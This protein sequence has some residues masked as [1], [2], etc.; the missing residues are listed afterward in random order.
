[1]GLS[2]K[3][4]KSLYEDTVMQIT[5]SPEEWAS[6]LNS[7][8]WM[9]EYDF[10]EQLLIYAQRPD[11]KACATIEDWNKKVYRWVKS[12]S[13]G[14]TILKYRDGKMK[15]EN[16]FDMADT[17]QK[18]GKHFNLWKLN[19]D[20]TS[21]L[22]ESLEA[23]YGEL[24]T[25]TDLPFAIIA[26]VENC[27]DDNIQDYYND[28]MFNI[29]G[30]NLER[31]SS[32]EIKNIYTSLIKVSVIYS[33]M[34]RVDEKPEKLFGIEDFKH[35][36]DF[37]TLATITAIGTAT[38]EIKREIIRE[39]RNFVHNKNHTFD[40][41]VIPKY[42]KSEEEIERSELNDNIQQTGRISNTEHS[43]GE[44]IS[45]S[46]REIRQ[47]EREL[48]KR[49]QE[50][51]LSDI[52]DDR[53]ISATF[54]G[55]TANSRESSGGLDRENESTRED[56]RRNETRKSDEMGRI[57]EQLE[58]DS[59]GNSDEGVNIQLD[60]YK[61]DERLSYVVV[62][63]KVNQILCETELINNRAVIDYFMLEKD[64]E[65][66][67]NFLKSAINDEYTG[68]VLY[69]EMY[70]Y[71]AF[72]NGVLF[73]KGNYLTKSAE[74]LISWE[75]L[76][77][78][79]D[80]MILLRQIR[81]KKSPL[82][83]SNG[84]LSLLEENSSSE[85]LEFTQEFLERYLSG[86][87]S[88]IKQ[89]I[90]EQFTSCLSAEENIKYIKDRYGISGA[91]S[92]VKGSGIGYD[93]SAKGLKL[94]RGFFEGRLEKTFSWKHIQETIAKLIREDKYLTSTEKSKYEIKDNTEK[95]VTL[96]IPKPITEVKENKLQSFN[97]QSESNKDIKN[98]FVIK[99]DKL[100]EGTPKER[101]KNNIEAIKVLKQC[102]A[103]NRYATTDEQEKLARYVG[104]GGLSQA[105]DEKNDSWKNEYKELK[106]L[107]TEEE[108]S[109]AR[110]ST[111]TAFYT[112]PIVI[113]SIYQ[114]LSNMGLKNGNILEPS[115]GTGNFI[116][117]I[118]EELS[119]CKMYG[120]ELDSITG[121]IAQQ[122]YQKSTIAIKGY[123]EADIPDTFFDAAVGNI[124]FG[125][126]KVTD[127]RYDKNNFL[128]H[129]YFFA[130]TLDKVR[131]GGIIAFITSKGT[132]DKE[133][134]SIR[135]YIAQR[136]DLLGAVRL[137]DNTFKGSAGT[138]VTTDII[139]LQKREQVLDI[140]PEWVHL[141]KNEDEIKM[142]RY[143]IDNPNMILGQ[144]KMETS[145][146]GMTANCKAFEN[147]DLSEL[148]E[149]A[150]SNIKA[151]I[152]DYGIGE[153]VNEEDTSIPAELNVKNFSYTII[154]D[155]IYYRDGSKMFLQDVPATNKSRIKELIKIRDCVRYLIDLQTEDRE[156]S[157]IIKEQAK[158]NK[159]YD[160]FVK[161]Y[162]RIYDNSNKRA[163]S[164]DS[165]YYLLCSLE[166][167]DDKGKFVRK[168]DMFS[169]RTIKPHRE[170]VAVATS[171]EALIV[172]I[173]EKAKVDL[174]YMS[175]LCSKSKDEI[176]SEL[177]GV[178]FKVPYSEDKYVTADEYL[179][180]NVREKLRTAEVAVKEDKSL[181]INVEML[182]KS[183]PKDLSAS[184]ISVRLGSTWLPEKY[185]E[186]FMYEL[187][188]TSRYN[189]EHIKVHYSDATSSWNISHKSYDN[190]NVK[191]NNTY[192]TDRINAYKIIEETLNL[193]SV[194]VF[195]TVYDEEGNKK[196]VL[197]K[198]DTAIAQAKQEQIKQAFQDWIWKEHDRREELTKLYNERFNSI[199]PR[200]YDGSHI[201]FGGINPEINLRKHQ[202]NAIAHILYGGNTLL[203]HEVGAGKTFEMVAAAM[204]SKRLNLCNKSIIVVP[205]HIVDQ[206]A[207]EFLQLYPSANL[208]V[209]TKKDFSTNYRKRFC[210]KIATGDY[211][212]II[213]GHSQFEK[214]PMSVER[215]KVLLNQQIADIQNGI[216]E[217]KANNGERFSI[218]DLE[219]SKKKLEEKLKKLN[220]QSRKD[221]VITFEQL[222][223]D[224][225]FV[226]EAH[227]YKNLFMYT[228]MRN[229]GGI[230]QTDA[231]KSSDLFMKCRY[232]DE[233]T[234]NK[235]VIFATGTPISNSMVELY[236]MQRYLQYDTLLENKLQHFDAW[237]STFGETVTAIE[238][239]PEGTGYRP[240]TRFAKFH[241]LPELM[242]MFKEIADIQTAD[243]LNLPAPDA[244]FHNVVVKPSE[245]QKSMVEELGKRAEKIRRG[246]ID[247]TVDNM[248]K[249]TND[250]RKLALDQRLLNPLLSDF[251]ESKINICANNIYKIWQE[252]I[253]EK[254]A[255]LAFCDLSTPKDLVTSKE[256]CSNVASDKEYEASFIDAYT[257]LKCKL[258]K[259]GIP[260]EEIAFIHEADDEMKKR[261]LFSKVRSGTVRVLI[262]STS[263]MGAGTNVQ[264]KLIALHDMD[265]PWRPADLTQRLGRIV[266]QGNSNDLVHIYRYV[267][268]ST[269]DAYL[270]QIVENK[271]KFI[272][273]IMT[274]KTPVRSANDVDETA[275][276]YAEI[277]ALAAG[278]PMIIEKT[279]LDS[280]VA[281]L[282]LL[283]QSFLSQKY[284]L[285]DRVIKF[286]P[287]E[288]VRLENL[289]N[290]L[291]EDKTLYD[292][293][294]K[295]Y[296]DE[297]PTMTVKGI[298]YKEKE[299]AGQAILETLKDVKN[300]LPISIGT[301][302]GFEMQI[303]YNSFMNLFKMDIRNKATHSIELGSDV[304]GNITRI[305]NAFINIEKAIESTKQDL[306]ETKRQFENAKEEIKQEFAYESELQEKIKRLTE[307]NNLLEIK[308]NE[309]EIVEDF[310]E[311]EENEIT[312]NQKEY[313]R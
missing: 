99:D 134:S 68:I 37:N 220:D 142:N 292:E 135:R 254:M 130:K 113:K 216:I 25:K 32:E 107:L 88:E 102:E 268:E 148:L 243:T 90:Y 291:E 53:A 269:F 203:A 181:E 248:L 223:V 127:K 265:C 239:S 81:N 286:Y 7:S 120:V 12:G 122:L 175:K 9:F 259:R 294:K 161:K 170:T 190:H 26:A 257:D 154:D 164:E 192:G 109:K 241:N 311:V 225:M 10:G 157:E 273:Q 309:D 57:N 206:F 171:S 101:Y 140:E 143:F 194:R 38:S 281:K 183:L 28:L 267:T 295:Q 279:Q 307:V 23:K 13:K 105:F 30:S 29:S 24:L 45:N 165:S 111:L 95:T 151:E 77:Y 14:I 260:S 49:P 168:A 129:D 227:N 58:N 133:N 298:T 240:K 256:M 277:K 215:Q 75:D 43:V 153:L 155:N 61:P 114:V 39:I 17:Y 51:N 272:A 209:T 104:W 210:S 87:N 288:I 52:V 201:V 236:T 96:E 41:V 117:M 119:N 18:Y 63:E 149:K 83:T 146:F 245:F 118:P 162:G 177:K 150:L 214:I 100:G 188:G 85:E 128:I 271:Q 212:A 82:V 115:C 147:T 72:S 282:K 123:E 299:Q 308:E 290:A 302:R 172:S 213:I 300:Q 141:G 145:Q 78:H 274:S 266:R 251:E 65:K 173:A 152:K 21:E 303:F 217:L 253:N 174:D 33:V 71:K 167:L 73:W 93:S 304:F 283:K 22:I 31:F 108:Y 306:E 103:E 195:D 258:I 276:S 92:T 156:E 35:I 16:V 261:E 144:M 196:R 193:K 238:L 124:P 2:Y 125:D 46:E 287:N 226:D 179:S 200:E 169:K 187:I 191:A 40:K 136:A 313:A 186:E 19:K 5:R 222:G 189:Q 233:I 139:F 297:F 252:N 198:K 263:K 86:R 8:L 285:E 110:E 244:K 1:M 250:G 79:Y 163:F 159:L 305:E 278:N 229:V 55:S 234:G 106:E 221:D 66:R 235:G 301:Y 94:Y 76:T 262:G 185:I 47:N 242:A 166:I 310:E 202:V 184:E 205:N 67:A 249:I 204:E 158:L 228:K 284:M 264:K 138:E 15:L 180:G 42:L 34:Q 80:S 27:V 137:P 60:V 199:K 211:D 11:A 89:E 219:R 132:L 6:F 270:Y 208:L 69:G 131:P 98:Q 50:S 237:A 312:E 44:R 207:G 247:P 56:N 74:S 4:A 182:K 70:G 91:T 275:L 36:E 160:D 296:G 62:D 289:I 64:V 97:L 293:S 116:G 231:Q 112:P 280:E 84:Q 218:K 178:I 126:F 54:D 230:A 20:Y 224:R 246:E 232:L 121:R 3:T 176:V 59:R 48:S 197:N 255:Q